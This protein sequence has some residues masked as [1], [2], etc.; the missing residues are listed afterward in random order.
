MPRENSGAGDARP[1]T[2]D[3]TL[4]EH[5]GPLRQ[6]GDDDFHIGDERAP[7][8]SNSPSDRGRGEVAQ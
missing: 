4:D 2:K 3:P 1:Q 6:E 7:G 5:D 8:E